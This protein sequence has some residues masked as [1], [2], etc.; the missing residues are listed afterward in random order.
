MKIRTLSQV[1]EQM[2]D[3]VEEKVHQIAGHSLTR[4]LTVKPSMCG[5]NSLLVGRIGDWTWDAVSQNCGVNAFSAVDEKGTTTYLSFFH[6]QLF[7]DRDFFLHSPTFG[8]RLQVTS[9][10]FAFG[11][12][13][14]V[15]I[16]R[17]SLNGSCQ[18]E[19]DI[20]PEELYGQRKPGCLYAM[21][22]NRWIQRSNGHSNTGLC[23][24]AP[25]GFTTTHLPKISPLYSPRTVYDQAR[26]QGQFERDDTFTELERVTV[27][28]TVSPTGDLNGVGLLYYTSYFSMVDKGAFASWQQQGRPSSEFM[29]RKVTKEQI[30]YLGNTDPG[31][32]LSII[33]THSRNKMNK[34]LERFDIQILE[35]SSKRVL[36]IAE[37]QYECF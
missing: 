9:S 25:V 7:G 30:L 4:E 28:Y 31:A 27:P 17:L 35:S 15:T 19:E 1:M 29:T 14:V 26:R 12:E 11:S 36:A 5:L 2:P 23:S 34:G 6:F 18:T 3:C 13:S 32:D 22:L 33:V 16:H 21:N 24:A 20:T 10:C 37:L 8:D